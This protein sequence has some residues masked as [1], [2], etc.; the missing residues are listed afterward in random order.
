MTLRFV[1]KQSVELT[2]ISNEAETFHNFSLYQQMIL[3]SLNQ[4]L[5]GLFSYPF[6]MIVSC[7]FVLVSLPFHEHFSY[8]S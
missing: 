6:C 5:L 3:A 1:D 4:Y 2:E 8:C 7:L